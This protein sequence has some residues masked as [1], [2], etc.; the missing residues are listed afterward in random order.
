MG[1]ILAI[2]ILIIK[3]L[4]GQKLGA[5]WHYGIWFLLVLRLL[6]P[7]APAASVNVFNFIPHYQEAIDLP[8]I[9]IPSAG[10]TNPATLTHPADSSANMQQGT[11]PEKSDVKLPRTSYIKA[12]FNWANLEIAWLI[13]ITVILFYI[14]LVNSLMLLRT[15][16]LP[17]CDSED[18]LRILKECKSSLNV[19]AK[20]SVIYDDNLKSPAIFGLFSKKIIISPEIIKKLAPEEIRCVFMH[21]ASHIKRHDLLI[22]GL[23]MVL[24][25]IYWFN[26]LIWYSL[27][28]MKQDCEIACD[29]TALAAM[30]KEDHKKYGQTIISLLQLLSKPSWIPGTLGFASKFNKRRIVM[31]SAFKKT[32]KKWII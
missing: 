13:G 11:L 31:I 7:Y 2:G 15:K 3:K 9:S 1:S 6:I 26:P 24:Q 8:K 20:V 17:T 22:N 5:N 32:T 29:A 10:E 30:K 19:H 12:W 27:S 14:F 16:K 18:I 4:L 21:E 25:V 23:V 28:Q